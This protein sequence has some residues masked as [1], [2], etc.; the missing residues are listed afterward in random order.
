M[1]EDFRE[2]AVQCLMLANYTMG[3]PHILETLIMILTEE[4]LLLKNSTTDGWLLVNTILRLA[5][6]MGYHRDSDHFPELSAFEAEMRRRVW[7]TI[8]QLDFV[9]SL[10]K[11]LPR[12]AIETQTD[13]KQPLN[14]RDD[15]FD[16]STTKLPPPRPEREWTP[17]LPLIAKARLRTALGLICDVNANINSLSRPE[18]ARINAILEDVHE[19]GIPP[20]LRW[21]TQPHPITESSSLLMQRIGIETTYHKS[22][23]LLWRRILTTCPAQELR[24]EDEVPVQICI[25]SALKILSFQELLFEES[26]PFGRLAQLKWKI[27]HIF[28]QDALLAT[29]I[30]C[31]YLQEEDKFR[32]SGSTVHTTW[33][34]KVEE[35]RHR[36]RIS[37][38]IWFQMSET[39]AEAGKAAKA[40]SIV[41]GVRDVSVVDE[42][43]PRDYDFPAD[44]DGMPLYGFGV[45]YADQCKGLRCAHFVPHVR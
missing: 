18:A 40:L 27:T 28:N 1:K 45:G 10:E 5:I 8:L 7:T 16:E 38:G 20:A 2:R 44:V 43:A 42:A 30:L 21:D 26:Q 22:R 29:S 32:A 25:D 34:S 39:S 36:L 4:S 14:L 31:L 9:L 11:G 12:G 37:H 33:S 23:I 6:L 41:L 17:I 15:D 24:E 35:I 3:G 13:T 19:R